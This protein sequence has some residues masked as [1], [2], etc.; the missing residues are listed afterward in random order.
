M[1]GGLEPIALA[2]LPLDPG[3]EGPWPPHKPPSS[4]LQGLEVETATPRSLR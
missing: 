3:F 1:V 4:S 2:D